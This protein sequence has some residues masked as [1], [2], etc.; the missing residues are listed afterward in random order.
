MEKHY[1]IILRDTQER[2]YDSFSVQILEKGN[3]CYGA[4]TD[5]QGIVQAKYTIYRLASMIAVYCCGDSSFYKDENVYNRIILA[6]DYVRSVQHANGLFDYVTC[7]F[8]SAPDTAFC[9]KKLM[10]VFFY[11]Q[12]ISRTD[13][14]EELFVR[15]GR[16]IE[17]AA[18]G[19][20]EGGF[21]TPNHRWAI[22]SSLIECAVIYEDE[23][24]RSCAEEYLIEGIV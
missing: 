5:E 15:I 19:M 21:H 2:V 16:I 11:L 10:P 7:N 3:P 8:N 1:Q 24:L 4:F 6:L 22:A 13:Q 20:M 17:V 23:N 14:E 12:G 9:I 18:H